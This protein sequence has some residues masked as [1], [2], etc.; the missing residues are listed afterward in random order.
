MAKKSKGKP[1]KKTAKKKQIKSRKKVNTSEAIPKKSEPKGESATPPIEIT[2]AQKAN[3]VRQLNEEARQLRLQCEE[4]IDELCASYGLR[5]QPYP[6][7]MADGR[8]SAGTN[9]IP[10]E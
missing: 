4:K 9:L 1:A 10:I 6:F 7:I 8:L 5:L 2:Q 3:I